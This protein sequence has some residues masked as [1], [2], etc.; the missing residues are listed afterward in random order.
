MLKDSCAPPN[1]H[2]HDTETTITLKFATPRCVESHCAYMFPTVML[3]DALLAPALGVRSVA[4][5]LPAP[6]ARSPLLLVR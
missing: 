3:I 6:S 5:C 2:L 4:D 1:L